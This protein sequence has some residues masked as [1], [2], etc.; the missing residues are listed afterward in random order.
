M[1]KTVLG[2]VAACAGAP[3]VALGI[4]SAVASAAPPSAET[5][6]VLSALCSGS[7]T[8]PDPFGSSVSAPTPNALAAALASRNSRQPLVGPGGSIIG[9]GLDADPATCGTNCDGSNGGLLLGNG[10]AGANGGTGGDG[11]LIGNGGAGGAAV[12]VN[13]TEVNT[14]TAIDITGKTGGAGGNGGALFGSGG[15]G[16][17]GGDVT[18]LT[19]NALGGA[20]G[21]GG[22]SGLFGTGGVG[23]LGGNAWS[24]GSGDVSATIKSDSIPIPDAGTT[25][26]PTPGI[27]F[28]SPAFSTKVEKSGTITT[29]TTGPVAGS[30]TGGQG[31]A[32]GASGLVGQGGAGGAGGEGKTVSPVNLG[33]GGAGGAGGTGGSLF[34][35]G[36][37]GGA[38][39]TGINDGSIQTT[40]ETTDTKT[41]NTTVL[42]LAIG[43]SQAAKLQG[44][45]AGDSPSYREQVSG[46][47]CRS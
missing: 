26:V 21:A 27:P 44:N 2:A 37:A 47:H 19:N 33:L 36:G 18:T 8:S 10:G 1:K 43:P 3:L 39:G 16:G 6:N 15:A 13:D 41:V 20:G 30:A 31:G 9:N 12:A 14:V 32:G 5:C 40:T 25:T 42:R 11:G 29:T 17:R 45:N 24:K 34:G 22:K 23:G 38:G 7:G 46:W 35:G 4:G 28:V